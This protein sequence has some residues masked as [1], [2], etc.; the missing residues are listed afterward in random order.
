MAELDLILQGA[1]SKTPVTAEMMD[2]AYVEKCDDERILRSI[3][4][5]LREK[6][7]GHFPQLDSAV[8]SKLLSLMPAARR[9]VLEGIRAGPSPAEVASETESLSEWIKAMEAGDLGIPK[10][11]N[12]LFFLSVP[13]TVFGTPY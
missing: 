6:H 7:E 5:E 12:R 8:E 1:T 2:Y 10:A 4:R 3:L 11:G 13:P 9:A